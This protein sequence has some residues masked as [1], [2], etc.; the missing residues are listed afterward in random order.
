MSPDLTTLRAH[1]IQLLRRYQVTDPDGRTAILREL[2]EDLVSVRSHFGRADGSPDWKGG[3]HPYRVFVRD[4][5]GEADVSKSQ[6][7]GIQAAIRYHVGAVLRQRL[8]ADALAE[9]GLIPQTPRQRSADRRHA[10]TAEAV[11]PDRGDVHSLV[12]GAHILL[13]QLTP[14]HVA[15]VPADEV[16]ELRGLLADLA[17]RVQTLQAG[18][19]E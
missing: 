19:L 12:S 3:S 6:Q 8:D 5:F 4:L 13:R 2:A 18:L 10:R 16:D 7:A 15:L 14:G 11:A 17:E 1:L 9:Y